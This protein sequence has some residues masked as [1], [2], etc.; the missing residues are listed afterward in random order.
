MNILSFYF[1]IA[2]IVIVAILF[3]TACEKDNADLGF[4]DRFSNRAQL[5]T[6]MEIPVVGWTHIGDSTRTSGGDNQFVGTIQDPIFGRT[7][8]DAYIQFELSQTNVNFGPGA[9]VDSVNFEVI[10]PTIFGNEKAP[11]TLNIYESGRA[12]PR[13]AGG[14]DTAVYSNGSLDIGELISEATF[15]PTPVQLPAVGNLLPVQGFRIPLNKDYFQSKIIDASADP[16][17]SGEF[18]NNASFVNY[19]KGLYFETVATNEALLQWNVLRGSSSTSGSRI[20]IYYRNENNDT[21]ASLFT[22]NHTVN[23]SVFCFYS[24]DYSSAE[25]DL[26]NQDSVN[27]EEHFFIQALAGV[28]TR[29]RFEGLKALR[30]S[31][32]II[33]YA[34]LNIPVRSGSLVSGI[35]GLNSLQV[36][37]RPTDAEVPQRIKDSDEPMGGQTHVG[38]NL[39][40]NEVRRLNYRFRLTRHINEI[41]YKDN[42]PE[43]ISL[44]AIQNQAYQRSVLNGTGFNDDPAT[45]KIYY[46]KP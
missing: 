38:G 36:F 43:T 4:D 7:A 11:M 23:N 29:I 1:K 17:T 22:L 15:I 41:I 20:N 5:G 19:F 21:T 33:N 2:I 18:A 8:A 42:I 27:G 39:T 32:F 12:I 26:G 45:L 35:A 9:I 28:E 3:F 46:T 14:F 13:S 6:L 10:M 25:F 34:E 24:H 37:T 16:A 31:G 44:R 40:R 30:D